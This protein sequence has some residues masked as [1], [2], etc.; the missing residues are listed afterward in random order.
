VYWV[1]H[2]NAKDLANILNEVYGAVEPPPED[3]LSLAPGLASA[4]PRYRGTARAPATTAR[5][6]PPAGAAGDPVVEEL[7]ASPAVRPAPGIF[8]DEGVLL[9]REQVAVAVPDERNNALLILATPSQYRG[10]LATLRQLDVVPLQVLI[11]ATIAEVRLTD[12]LRYGLQWFFAFG[13]S[14]ATLSDVTSG[15]VSPLFPGFSYL[16]SR[17]DARVVLNAL[18]SVTDVRI[19]SAPQLFVRDNAQ[20][21]LQVG[22][23][24]PIVTQQAI[25]V[26]D[27]DAP[28]VNT[29][30][31]RDTGVILEVIPHVNTS[32]SVILEIIQEVSDVVPTESSGIDS[33][34]IQRRQI[35][36]EVFMMSG[37]TVALGGLIRDRQTQGVS[38]IPLL[39]EIPVL[40]NLFKT[41]SDN[42]DRTELLVL[43]TPRVVRNSQDAAALTEE[44][45][46][47]IPSV[48][49]LEQLLAPLVPV[50]RNEQ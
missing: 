9:E 42:E 29:V 33:P 10:I 47:R 39:S 49:Q 14:S 44:L 37:E 18:T 46:R 19:I 2:G 50:P 40:G 43:L 31:Y 38:G 21:R 34:T 22:D 24:V 1:Q 13:S 26:V 48:T 6:L 17:V 15:A 7:L 12:Q 23:Q 45:R 27:S 41:T 5:P 16:Y 36:S 25:S 11:E 20:A 32:G 30:E 3:A 35:A 8:A 4:Q 28:L